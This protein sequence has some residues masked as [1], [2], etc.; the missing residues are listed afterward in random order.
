MVTAPPRRLPARGTRFPAMRECRRDQRLSTGHDVCVPLAISVLADRPDLAEATWR[1]PDSWPE[2]MRHDPIGGL[3]Y[4][5]LETRFP[6]FVLVAQDDAGE[7]VACA[8]SVPFVL[9]DEPLPD[10]GWDFVVRNGLLTS[11]R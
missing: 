11:L 1:M 3:F 8:Y 5:N 6:E 10:N 9:G 2:F 7:V 4:G